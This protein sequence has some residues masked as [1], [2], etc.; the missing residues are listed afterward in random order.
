MGNVIF[1]NKLYVKYIDTKLV[2]LM[3]LSQLPITYD[4]FP[5]KAVTPLLAKRPKSLTTPTTVISLTLLHPLQ[6]VPVQSW[7]FENESVI[8]IGRSAKNN[9]VLYSAVVSRQHLEIRR[10][11]AEWEIINLGANGTYVE[12]KKMEKITVFDG[13]VIRLASSGP[14]ICI[15][16]NPSRLTEKNKNSRVISKCS[17]QALQE[18]SKDTLIN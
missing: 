11:R 13:I 6:S 1:L 9:V 18:K 8:R 7:L 17:S 14:Q 2:R 3:S 12:G 15:Q 4:L 16:I 10:N 5:K